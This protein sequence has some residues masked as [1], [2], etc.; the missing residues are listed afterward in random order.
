MYIPTAFEEKSVEALRRLIRTYPFGALVTTSE[1]GE[2]FATH[3]PFLLAEEPAPNG[4]LMGH[5]ARANSQWRDFGR[6]VAVAIFQGPHAYISPSWYRSQPSVPTWNY[7]AVHAYGVPAVTDEA[8]LREI[9]SCS[10][11]QFDAGIGDGK[12]NDLP[13]GYTEKMMRGIVGF[14]MPIGRL[15]GKFKLSQNRSSEDIEAVI[16]ALNRQPAP[17]SGLV[18]ALMGACFAAEPEP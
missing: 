3:L 12:L 4:M 9:L 10:L 18:A 2:P 6:G 15:E 7:V 11:A 17:D 16:E 14:K 8:G 13:A 5:V 1:Q